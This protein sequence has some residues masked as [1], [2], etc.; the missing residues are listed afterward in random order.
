MGSLGARK[1]WSWTPPLRLRSSSRPAEPLTLTGCLTNDISTANSRP[2]ALSI[3]I[4]EALLRWS[5]THFGQ[6]TTVKR[7]FGDYPP[8]RLKC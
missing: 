7:W 2:R 1:L 6:M 3:W 5:I 8:L 4:T